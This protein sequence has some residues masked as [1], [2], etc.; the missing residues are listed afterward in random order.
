MPDEQILAAGSASAPEAYT[1]P[2]A[3]EIIVKAVSC[4]MDGTGASGPFFPMLSIIPPGGVG[5]IECPLTTSIAAGASAEVSWFPGGLASS[6]LP[7]YQDYVP[8]VSLTGNVL[9]D[10]V[11][12]YCAAWVQLEVNSLVAGGAVISLGTDLGTGPGPYAFDLIPHPFVIEG[13][14]LAIIYAGFGSCFI[15]AVGHELPAYVDG[16]G[17]I[18]AFDGTTWGQ[19]TPTFPGTWAAGDVLFNGSW[20]GRL[21]L[22]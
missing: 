20:F 4:T 5:A 15:G 9:S 22:E 12:T 7:L 10:P 1:V 3:Q 18:Y 14:F 21:I 8:A 19:T 13:Y 2:S 11:I 16:V 6:T 17:D